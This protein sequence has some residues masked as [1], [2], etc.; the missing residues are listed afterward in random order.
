MRLSWFSAGLTLAVFLTGTCL[1]AADNLLQNPGF[2][3][4][5]EGWWTFGDGWRVNTPADGTGI[6]AHAGSA[7]VIHEIAPGDTNTGWRGLSQ[8]L[9]LKPGARFACGVWIKAL[10]K[11]RPEGYLEIQFLDQFGQILQNYQSHSVTADLP[12]TYVSVD[13]VV[14]PARTATALVRGIVHLPA[15]SV[16]R[17]V[18]YFDDFDLHEISGAATAPSGQGKKHTAVKRTVPGNHLPFETNSEPWKKQEPVM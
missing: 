4:G 2:E 17:T 14:A 1:Q 10:G 7:C 8:T 18:F 13:N 12:F 6:V 15:R 3:E 16:G 9:S 5:F 11:S